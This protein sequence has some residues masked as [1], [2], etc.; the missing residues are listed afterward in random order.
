VRVSLQRVQSQAGYTLVEVIIASA[1]GAILMAALTSVILTSVQATN[2]ARSRVEASSQI[3]SFQFFA[4]D[5]FAYS[6]LPVPNGCGTAANPC[7]TQPIV[8]SGLRASNSTTPVAA[9]YT[10]TYTWDGSAFVDRQAGSAPA[11]H[12]AIDV[13]AFSWY[14]A[15]TAPK[16]SVIVAMTVTVSGYSESQ[17]LAF[18]PE[19][20]P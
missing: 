8:L 6:S 20:N 5:D 15:G 11:D 17:T 19:V 16:Q 2:T 14:L 1:I 4:R 3:R 9:P 7:T 18:Y 10:T 13:T 12:A